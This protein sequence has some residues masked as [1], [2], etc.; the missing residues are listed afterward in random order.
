MH[1]T[2]RPVATPVVAPPASTERRAARPG[3]ARHALVC[4]CIACA[5]L[6]LMRWWAWA[7]APASIVAIIYLMYASIEMTEAR[8]RALRDAWR[9]GPRPRTRAALV[10]RE[11]VGATILATLAIGILSIAVIVAALLL[12]SQMLGVG[13]AMVFCAVVFVGLPTW[14]ASVGD[15]LPE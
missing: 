5:M 11:R 12:D 14:A 13:T 7:W 15:T 8:A 1:N 4:T 6:V 3:W 10:A 9:A 2:N